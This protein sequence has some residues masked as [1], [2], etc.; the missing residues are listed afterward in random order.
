M[1]LRPCSKDNIIWNI[2]LTGSATQRDIT[3][4]MSTMS[5]PN[6]DEYVLET[7]LKIIEILHVRS[8][9]SCCFW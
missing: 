7:K 8:F 1:L 5:P 6:Q 3:H 9:F 2:Y 4:S